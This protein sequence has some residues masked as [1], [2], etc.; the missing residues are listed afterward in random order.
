[1]PEGRVI[2]GL[3][4]GRESRIPHEIVNQALFLGHRLLLEVHPQLKEEAGGAMKQ[5]LQQAFPPQGHRFGAY[6]YAYD[7]NNNDYEAGSSDVTQRGEGKR[8]KGW[9]GGGGYFGEF[10][11]Y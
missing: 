2:P 11:T 8:G 10:I 6:R 3:P 7:S 5:F 4:A 1:M 9:G